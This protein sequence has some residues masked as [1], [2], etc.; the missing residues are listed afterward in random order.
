MGKKKRVK[1]GERAD[2]YAKVI[3]V[4]RKRWRRRRQRQRFLIILLARA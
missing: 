3:V 2:R 1:V 4:E